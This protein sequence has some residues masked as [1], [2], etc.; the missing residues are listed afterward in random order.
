MNTKGYV[1]FLK[2]RLITA[3]HETIPFL[4]LHP[5]RA[6]LRFGNIVLGVFTP[7]LAK[8]SKSF[9]AWTAFSTIWSQCSVRSNRLGFCHSHRSSDFWSDFNCYTFL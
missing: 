8:H 1:V 3:G 4:I 5:R 9:Q 7:V 6:R 2:T